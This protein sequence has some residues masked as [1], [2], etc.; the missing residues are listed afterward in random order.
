MI[1]NPAYASDPRTVARD[2]IGVFE[3]VF[4]R[5]VPGIVMH[6]NHQYSRAVRDCEPIAD[7]E[8]KR[9]KLQRSMLFEIAI[10]AAEMKYQTRGD[11]EWEA[12]LEFAAERQQRFYDAEIPHAVQQKDRELVMAIS[13]NL[14]LML[15][16][17]EISKK[18][19]L[20]IEPRIPG[21]G[22]IS[23]GV[24]DYAVG[25]AIVEVKCTR[26]RFTSADFRQ[27]AIYW[28]L[29]YIN[30]LEKGSK[31]WETCI[32]LNPRKNVIVEIPLNELISLISGGRSTI[33]VVQS[34]SACFAQ[35]FEQDGAG[36]ENF[37]ARKEGKGRAA[38]VRS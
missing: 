32:L 11:F 23:N 27:V 10:V 34:F 37:S 17:L 26:K 29:S 12:C 30:H 6:L 36:S 5:L 2:I 19:K 22:W 4:P 3:A 24:G 8:I 35:L 15:R 38:A 7:E 20:V 31:A 33:E 14:L 9:S 25:D 21:F 1:A 18:E 13:E 16:D 28:L